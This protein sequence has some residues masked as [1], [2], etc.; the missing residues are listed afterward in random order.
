MMI[1]RAV[2]RDL[3]VIGEAANS[4]TETIKQKYP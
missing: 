1:K 4:I 3:E 2:I